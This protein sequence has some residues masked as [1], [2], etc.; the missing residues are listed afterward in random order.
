MSSKPPASGGN[1]TNP[2]VC[3]QCLYCSKFPSPLAHCVPESVPI[4][5]RCCT[6]NVVL[7]PKRQQE[8]LIISILTEFVWYLVC[9]RFARHPNDT[10]AIRPFRRMVGIL[11]EMMYTLY[12][13]MADDGPPEPSP[14]QGWIGVSDGV[15]FH[16]TL[17]R[18]VR[19]DLA[20][21]RLAFRGVRERQRYANPKRR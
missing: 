15:A 9:A 11:R 19:L 17:R 21:S 13:E 3:A 5:D 14:R 20:L 1:P 2:A 4:A 7:P 16:W 12:T 10:A 6:R 18:L 8:L